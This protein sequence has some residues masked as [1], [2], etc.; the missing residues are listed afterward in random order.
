MHQAVYEKSTAVGRATQNAGDGL[1]GVFIRETI[2][3]QRY[4]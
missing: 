4:V 3:D 2:S 1:A